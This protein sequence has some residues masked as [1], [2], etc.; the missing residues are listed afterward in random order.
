MPSARNNSISRKKLF[1]SALE[2]EPDDYLAG[3]YRRSAMRY[4]E[5]PP[6]ADWDGVRV[7]TEK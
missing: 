7:M 4:A 5:E 1:E 3:D 6:P 2:I